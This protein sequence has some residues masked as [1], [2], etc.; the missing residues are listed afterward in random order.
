MVG[1]RYCYAE[2]EKKYTIVSTIGDYAKGIIVGYR[3][4]YYSEFRRFY[5]SLDMKHLSFK[6]KAEYSNQIRNRDEYVLVKTFKHY[7]TQY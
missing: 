5:N 2:I 1:G 7:V 6:N 4:G 3:D